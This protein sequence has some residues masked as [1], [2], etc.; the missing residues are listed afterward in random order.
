MISTATILLALIWL[1]PLSSIDIHDA[2]ITDI[3]S[4]SLVDEALEAVALEQGVDLYVTSF[5]FHDYPTWKKIKMS[6]WSAEQK[7]EPLL[8]Q[9]HLIMLAKSNL[10]SVKKNQR[11]YLCKRGALFSYNLFRELLELP[12]VTKASDI[13]QAWLIEQDYA[14]WKKNKQAEYNKESALFDLPKALAV[15][16]Q[17]H[18][19]QLKTRPDHTYYS[20]E[21]H[22]TYNFLRELRNQSLA[23][24]I[25]DIDVSWVNQEAK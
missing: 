12:I 7:N 14:L 9:E 10:E 2:Q 3:L 6:E 20:R 17:F 16:I 8:Q 15:E 25:Q 11:D 4:T 18:C 5:Y 22:Y 13:D 24:S 19:A 21:A 1:S 23:I